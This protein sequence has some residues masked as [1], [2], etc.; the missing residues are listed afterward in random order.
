MKYKDWI[1]EW[2][3][4][5]VKPGVKNKTY[6]NYSTMMRIHILPQLG[7]YELEDLSLRVLQGFVLHLGERGNSKT[8]KGLSPST[9]G[10]VVS[11]M[12][13]SLRF[14][15][16]IGK[17]EIQYSDHVKKP[18]ADNK[19]LE[20]FTLAEQKKIECEVLKKP[21]TKSI[22]ILLCLY[23]GLR[24]GEL[25]A[26]KWE[27][28]DFSK[29]VIRVNGTCRDGYQ[30]G[31]FY[32]ILDTPK[33]DSSKRI[34]PMPRQIIPYLRALKK[35]N[36]GE[37]VISAC[38]GDVSVRSYQK[39]FDGMLKR[40]KIEHRCFHALRH[41]FA[42]RALECGMDV[43]TLSEILGHKNP[44]ITLNRYAHSM[45]DHKKAMMNRVG[46]FLQ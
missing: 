19:K 17:V 14:A 37:Y 30:D 24:I 36:K 7:E 44:N 11:V 27:D 5:Y 2:L 16:E 13:K 34:I 10:L 40:L 18:K 43:K 35:S 15:V 12:Q 33:T 42:S 46:R 25:M 38:G 29:G 6:V 26:L 1:N 45:M 23:T 28:V 21:R 39:S 4:Y 32:K 20:C 31:V 22:G 41:T 9:V 3:E 8:G